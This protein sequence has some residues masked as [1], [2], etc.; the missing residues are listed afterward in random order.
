MLEKSSKLLLTENELQSVKNG[1]IPFRIKQ[2]WDLPLDELLD[3]I[4]TYQ[5]ELI[6]D[7]PAWSL[8]DGADK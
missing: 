6:F 1:E 5:Y 8:K 4:R 2:N 3:I 7:L